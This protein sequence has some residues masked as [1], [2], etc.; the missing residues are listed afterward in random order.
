MY[1]FLMIM[2]SVSSSRRHFVSIVAVMPTTFF[3]RALY[4]MVLFSASVTDVLCE[5]IGICKNHIYIHYDDIAA[6]S[7]A[8]TYI[9]RRYFR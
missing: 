7:V 1:C 6:W 4:R 9:D 2:E 5:L 3:C 8:G